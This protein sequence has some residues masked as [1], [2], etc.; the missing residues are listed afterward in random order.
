[1][2]FWSAKAEELPPNWQIR[3]WVGENPEI[4]RLLSLFSVPLCIC[5]SASSLHLSLSLFLSAEVFQF[6]L[7]GCISF[8]FFLLCSTMAK[9]QNRKSESGR[10]IA[11][12]EVI[13]VF[14]EN[15]RY[16]TTLP[17]TQRTPLPT[18]WSAQTGIALGLLALSHQIQA[19]FNDQTL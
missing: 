14:A 3:P 17:H 8:Y 10:K 11:W 5:P 1:M 18:H 16:S 12:W 9:C 13:G 19:L 2:N 6:P 4:S 15:K 7:S